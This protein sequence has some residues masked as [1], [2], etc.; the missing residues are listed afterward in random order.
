M[1]K[2]IKMIGPVGAIVFWHY[3]TNECYN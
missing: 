3:M 2:T 1:T